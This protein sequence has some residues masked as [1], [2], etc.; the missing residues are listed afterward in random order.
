M[1]RVIVGVALAAVVATLVA[2][3]S[4][5]YAPPKQ[6]AQLLAAQKVKV[7][8]YLVEWPGN[9]TALAYYAPTHAGALYAE[10]SGPYAYYYLFGNGTVNVLIEGPQVRQRATYYGRLLEVCRNSTITAVVAGERITLSDSR[11]SPSPPLPAVRAL[12][13]VVFGPARIVWAKSGVAQ[14]PFGPAE[15]YANA[16]QSQTPF[17]PL[18]L[19]FEKWVLPDGTIYLLKAQQ[20]LN[21]QPLYSVSY[22]LKNVTAITQELKSVVDELSKDVAAANGGGLDLLKAAGKIGM[23]FDGGWPAAVVFFDLQC[24]YCAMLFKYNYTLFQGHKLV[25]V[26]LLVHPE[27]LEAHQRLRCLYHESPDR[28]LPALLELYERLLAG[29]ADYAGVLPN[30][31]CPVDAEAGMQLAQLALLALG[32]D[33]SRELGTPMVVAVYPNGTYA[34]VTGYRPDLIAAA[35]KQ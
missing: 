10:K 9:A 30:R 31:T 12:E 32:R 29:G 26:D 19:A 14:T 28:V 15:V 5:T 34:L 7:Y 11:C 8:I 27:A 20:T 1:H 4:L 33:P 22:T 25:L 3:M 24:P 2:L 21:G 6:P 35:L 13:D 18:V 23:S 16:T 17:G